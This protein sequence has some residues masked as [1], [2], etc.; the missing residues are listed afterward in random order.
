MDYQDPRTSAARGM[1]VINDVNGSQ[2]FLLLSAL[3]FL[4]IAY[5]VTSFVYNVYFHPLSKFPGPKFAAY[6]R[7]P[8]LRAQLT[9]KLPHY[10]KAL[11]DQYDSNVV[12][13]SPDDLSFTSPSAWNDMFVLQRGRETFQKDVIIYGNPPQ[14]VHAVL[15]AN[16]ADHVRMRRIL[17]HAF[18]EKALKMQEPLIQSHVN[19]LIDQLRQCSITSGGK[20]DVEAFFRWATF[21]IMGELA[22]GE[23][24]DCLRSQRHRQWSSMIFDLS[25]A[26]VVMSA[27]RRYPWSEKTLRHFLPKQLMR[28]TANNA[29]LISELVDRRL[30]GGNEKQDFCS[31]ILKYNDEKGMTVPEIKANASLFMAA[32]TDSSATILTG[33]IY[34]LTQNSNALKRLSHEIRNAFNTEEDITF[35]ST[36]KLPYLRAVLDESTRMYPPTLAG[37]PHRV[38]KGGAMISGNWVPAGV[39]PLQACFQSSA[40]DSHHPLGRRPNQPMGSLPIPPK[41]RRAKHLHSG[42]LAG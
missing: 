36:P 17:A 39:I 27:S 5:L 4:L 10:I 20:V 30:K 11:H 38:P 13:I 12:R 34:F 26:L 18:S 6:T 8:Y 21:D 24:I 28:R 15:T 9:G 37:Q 40:A 16:D 31:Y 2:A 29:K 33:C 14:G 35:A 3:S 32:G 25:K 41:F 7:I 22:F 42:A 23:S 19:I 1:A